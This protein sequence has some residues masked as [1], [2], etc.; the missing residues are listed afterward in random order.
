MKTYTSSVIFKYGDIDKVSLDSARLV[1]IIN[2]QG[3]T[4]LIDLI[5]E[6]AGRTANRLK[7]SESD[8]E[9]LIKSLTNELNEALKERL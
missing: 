8:R 4:L 6:N 3:T 5:S 9:N 1:D 2:R 7:L